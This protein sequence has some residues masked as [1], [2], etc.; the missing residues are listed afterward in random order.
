MKKQKENS[1][2]GITWSEMGKQNVQAEKVYWARNDQWSRCHWLV[3]LLAWLLVLSSRTSCFLSL[4]DGNAWAWNHLAH[5]RWRTI[6]L[7]VRLLSLYRAVSDLV[8]REREASIDGGARWPKDDQIRTE[9]RLSRAPSRRHLMLLSCCCIR[10][11]KVAYY[12]FIR[13]QEVY[14]TN[15]QI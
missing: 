2:E 9:F 11:L 6:G 15:A 12:S 8:K 4:V 1:H 5:V 3:C 14:T 7:R 10:D 13:V